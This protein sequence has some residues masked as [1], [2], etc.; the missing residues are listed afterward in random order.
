MRKSLLII[1][2]TILIGISSLLTW[3][4]AST[5][6]DFTYT[7]RWFFELREN[8]HSDPVGTDQDIAIVTIDE[9]T[10]ESIPQTYRGWAPDHYNHLIRNLSDAGARLVAFYPIFGLT[11]LPYDVTKRELYQNL[12]GPIVT[13]PEVRGNIPVLFSEINTASRYIGKMGSFKDPEEDAPVDVR[14]ARGIN[15]FVSLFSTAMG[16]YPVKN[17]D[18]IPYP[19]FELEIVEKLLNIRKDAAIVEEDN[20]LIH[21]ELLIPYIIELSNFTLINYHSTNTGSQQAVSRGTIANH[22]KSQSLFN[23]YS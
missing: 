7:L 2:Y 17:I 20:F 13:S 3:L 1:F 12:T 9:K 23:F 15:N 18:D 16:F 19:T 11:N 6:F 14:I 10:I 22:S 5:F 8:V 21:G 4:S